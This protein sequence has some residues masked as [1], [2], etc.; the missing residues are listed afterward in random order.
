[1]SFFHKILFMMLFAVFCVVLSFEFILYENINSVRVD[2]MKSLALTQAKLIASNQNLKYAIYNE[3]NIMINRL[4]ENYDPPENIDYVSI[5]NSNQIRLFH[6]EGRGIGQSLVNVDFDKIQAGND[7]TSVSTGIENKLLIKARVPVFYNGTFFGIVSVGIN[8]DDAISELSQRYWF[9]LFLSLILLLAFAIFSQKLVSYI[10]KKM[11][12]Q[13]P[14]EIE[15]ALKLRQGILNTVFEGVVSVDKDNRFLVINDSGLRD[16]HI[17]DP[18][19]KVHGSY[20]SEYIYPTDFFDISNK[21]EVTNQ[22][23]T[24]N[25][26]ALI[27]NRKFMYNTQGNKTGAVISFRIKREIEELEQTINA[28]NND[29]ENLRA[30]IHEFNNQMSIIY[31]LLQMEQY[32]KAMNFI[33]SEHKSKQSDIYHISKAF[34]ISTL[35]ALILSK[36]S[37][38]KELGI[39]LEVDPLSCIH[40]D[41]L[42]I[43]ENELNCIVGNLLNNAFE[44]IVASEPEDRLVRLYIHQGNDLIIEVEDSGSGIN[45]S[46]IG[47]IF[48]RKYTNK[49][50]PNHGI[51]LNL[52][53]NIVSSADGT[54]IVE[55][56]ELGGA[57]FNIY[58]PIS[59]KKNEN[60]TNE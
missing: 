17:L 31:G 22:I 46:D 57:L 13:S 37:R 58:M 51:G 25:G 7:V 30:I 39:T 42:P 53:N 54:I 49:E 8:Y 19:E 12:H 10:R 3:D 28:A 56:S 43:N 52:I 6:S 33:R 15:M 27:A 48:H 29:K 20:I 59:D 14:Q 5:S 55:G 40:S 50:G 18:R 32:K 35:V 4:M 44:S 60:T 47:K 45:E 36:V 9:I 41:C 11:H 26:E 2:S 24:C 38:A 1:M 34:Q 16:L 21:D 23:I